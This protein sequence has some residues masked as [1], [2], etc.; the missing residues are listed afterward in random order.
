VITD[1][2]I[3]GF[4]GFVSG[5]LSLV[6]SFGIP[7]IPNFN[8]FGVTIGVQLGQVNRFV[9]LADLFIIIGLALLIAI[10][11]TVWHGVLFVYH[12]FWGSS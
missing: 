7:G 10:A 9:P 12:Q 11:M 6:P 1:A 5:F 3:S 2:L 8:D 4:L